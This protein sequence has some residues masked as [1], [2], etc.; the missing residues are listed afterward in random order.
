LDAGFPASKLRD[1]ADRR[2]RAKEAVCFAP[3]PHGI[4]DL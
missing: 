1:N 4:L 3:P 2:R